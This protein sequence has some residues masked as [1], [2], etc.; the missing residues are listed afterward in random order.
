M[1]D[2]MLTFGSP[3]SKSIYLLF[4]FTILSPAA[5]KRN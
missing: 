5:K 3:Q 4:Y 2:K 1:K